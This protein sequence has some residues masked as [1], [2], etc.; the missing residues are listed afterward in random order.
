MKLKISNLGPINSMEIDM[1]KPFILFAGDNSTGKTYAAT[2]LYTLILELRQYLKENRNLLPLKR[3]P[4]S[5]AEGSIEAND[6]FKLFDSFLKEKKARVIVNVCGHSTEEYVNVVRRLAEP[7][8]CEDID[9]LEEIN[10]K[11][12]CV[13]EITLTT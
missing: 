2:F 9:L 13:V 4:Q 10:R 6:L 7:D 11:A 12:K 8:V 3:R 5:D 1:S